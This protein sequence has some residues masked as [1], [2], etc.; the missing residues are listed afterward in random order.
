MIAGRHSGHARSYL[1]DD[2][3][4]LMAEHHR[5]P[6]REIAVSDVNVGVTKACVGVADENLALPRPI[7]VELFDL[8]ALAWLV[9][10]SSLGLHRRS[11]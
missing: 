11:S 4:T 3:C 2:P 6:R 9:N 7:Q 10:D 5:K 8:D 1:L